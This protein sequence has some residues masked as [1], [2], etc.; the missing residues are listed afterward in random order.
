MLRWSDPALGILCRKT[1]APRTR[2]RSIREWFGLDAQ[3]KVSP[4]I[5]EN[6]EL[7]D[8]QL[9]PLLPSDSVPCEDF[10]HKISTHGWGEP[11]G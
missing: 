2:R 6:H 10:E 9:I 5:V 1:N 8:F 11:L 3:R 4:F 7:G